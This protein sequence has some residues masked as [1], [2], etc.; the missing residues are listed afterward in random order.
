MIVAFG[1]KNEPETYGL[2]ETIC[3]GRNF[4]LNGVVLSITTDGQTNV[5]VKDGF[6]SGTYVS[7]FFKMCWHLLPS[8]ILFFDTLNVLGINTS[9]IC[10]FRNI[11]V[12]KGCNE[13]VVIGIFVGVNL[14]NYANFYFKFSVPWYQIWPVQTLL[15]AVQ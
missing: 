10:R 7:S 15:K 3:V 2:F 6:V 14:W 8:R 11:A 13:K 4:T 1:T 9:S 5:Y 12:I